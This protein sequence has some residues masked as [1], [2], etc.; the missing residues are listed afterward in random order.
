MAEFPLE[1]IIV[2]ED[3]YKIA[4]G[5]GG[6][7]LVFGEWDMLG[8]G[9]YSQIKL[10]D[11]VAITDLNVGDMILVR[12][13]GYDIYVGLNNASVYDSN[14]NHKQLAMNE[15]TSFQYFGTF[16]RQ[17]FIITALFGNYIEISYIPCFE[18]SPTT[19]STSSNTTEG[20]CRQ[21]INVL[22][23]G[24]YRSSSTYAP[25]LIN[26]ITGE[27]VD[28]DECYTVSDARG[29]EAFIVQKYSSSLNME[30]YDQLYYTTDVNGILTCVAVRPGT[31]PT[32][33][34]SQA[35]LR[36]LPKD[37]PTQ[38]EIIGGTLANNFVIFGVNGHYVF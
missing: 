24:S 3:T 5:G 28:P 2:G 38:Y 22:G 20:L 27:S 33:L 21:L 34:T 36:L 8:A 17:K 9:K 6:S 25:S 29:S 31:T 11:N 13:A 18:Y 4:S 10:K 23:A 14:G 1:K 32:S 15:N 16:R 30:N 7:K 12:S 37:G 19:I 26:Y 35:S